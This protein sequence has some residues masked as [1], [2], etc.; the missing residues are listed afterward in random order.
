MNSAVASLK[1]SSILIKKSTK[2]RN[3]QDQLGALIK[4]PHKCTLQEDKVTQMFS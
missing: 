3:E 2:S 1:A 4:P